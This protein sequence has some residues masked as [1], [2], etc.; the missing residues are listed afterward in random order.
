MNFSAKKKSNHVRVH[1]NLIEGCDGG[2]IGWLKSPCSPAPPTH[3]SNFSGHLSEVGCYQ[4]MPT[5]CDKAMHET[6]TP[7]KN[8]IPFTLGTWHA[9]P[10]QTIKKA[11]VLISVHIGNKGA[12]F[13][14]QAVHSRSGYIAVLAV[15]VLDLKGPKQVMTATNDSHRQLQA[16]SVTRSAAYLA[17]IRL[18]SILST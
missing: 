3:H 4:V 9:H 6:T 18:G 8:V 13:P 14:R 12:R 2:C 5:G 11:N 7:E 1:A 17:S 15:L 16:L 10:N